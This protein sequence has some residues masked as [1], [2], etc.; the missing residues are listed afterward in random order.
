M[1]AKRKFPFFIALLII[2]TGAISSTAEN[3][4][5]HLKLLAVQE[6]PDGF[7]GSDADL[8]L[9]LKEGSGRVF[10]D[11]FP[12]TKMDTQI[13]TRFAKEIA[14]KHF[15]LNCEKY[16]YIFTIKSKSSIIGG[17]SA[18][19]AIAALTTIAVLDLEYDPTITLTGTINS[20]GIVGPVGGVKE[21]LEAASAAGLQKVLIAKGTAVQKSF[22]IPDNVSVSDAPAANDSNTSE[23]H[24]NASAINLI[25][26]GKENL[27]LEVVEVVDLDDVIFHLTGKQLNHKDITITEYNGYTEIMK[28]LQDTLCE[29]TEKMEQELKEEKA[30]F[31][32]SE[33]IL[34]KKGSAV[35]ATAQGDY[36]S[37]ASF[38]FT[39]NIELK[40][41]YYQ[42]KSISSS[43]V[44]R[45]F[46]AVE[47]KANDLQE[48]L[49]AEKR[50]TVSDIQTYS[51]VQERLNDV[52]AQI[53]RYR[54]GGMTREEEYQ[55][56]AY[57]EER[58]FSALSWMQFFAMDGKQFVLNQEVLE[59]SCLQKIAEGEERLQY[60]SLFIGDLPLASIREKLDNAQ[61]VSQEKEFE[62]CLIKAAEVKANADAIISS[63]GLTEDIIDDF[64]E[65]KRKAVE[66]VI[67]ENSAEGVFPI[68][69]YSYYQYAD[70][71]K[72]RDKFTSLLYLEYALELSDLGIYFPEEKT[73]LEKLE[74]KFKSKE[75]WLL[76]GEG[77]V[78]GFLFALIIIFV[79]NMRRQRKMKQP[80]KEK[81]V[82]KK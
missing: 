42:E 77:F 23:R 59:N 41:T 57:A 71:W 13:S 63:L 51:V 10:L 26:Y 15:N 58:F 3:D 50:E 11:T 52:E 48:K 76:V 30:S 47:Q 37:A 35:N 16:D 20:G 68:L 72:D 33:S 32:V 36:Y 55:L 81:F 28:K 66:R 56:L 61:K 44:R 5:Y 4:V 80:R 73:F 6:T 24:E 9:E 53:E 22:P 7:T 19:A 25:A 40:T 67:A 18:G 29:R 74:P 49:A 1:I 8:F 12:V 65:S 21:K 17:P 2:F 79:M 60:A 54:E 45:L 75:E 34:Q 39:A 64:L 43:M 78:A 70:S 14:C 27:S 31:N 38:C 46:E 69:G 82:W 62:L